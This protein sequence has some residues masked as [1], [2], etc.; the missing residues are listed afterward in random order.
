MANEDFTFVTKVDTD[1]NLVF[2]W[3]YVSVDKSG[4]RIMDHSNE[5]I[6]IEDLEDAAYLFN[7]AFR[8]S[9]VMHKGEAVGELVESFVSTPQ[10]LEKMGLPKESLPTGW[11]VGFYIEDDE[12]FAKVKDGTYSMFSIQG[13]AI[14]EEV[15]V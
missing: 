12:V 11:W 8:D 15:T 6:D 3:A 5:T 14:R 10:K 13:K 2:G 7:L 4:Q 1:R 9:G